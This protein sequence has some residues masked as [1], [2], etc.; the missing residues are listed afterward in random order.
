MFPLFRQNQR[1]HEENDDNNN[2]TIIIVIKLI[3]NIYLSNVRSC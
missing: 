3:Y 2:R 1:A